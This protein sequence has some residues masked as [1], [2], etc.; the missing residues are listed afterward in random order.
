VAGIMAS[1]A[2]PVHLV[3]EKVLDHFNDEVKKEGKRWVPDSGASNHMSDMQ[4]IFVELDTNIHGTVRFGDGS[5]VEIMGIGTILFVCRNG[6]HMALTGVY[7]I[8][9]LTTNIM[10]L[11]Q[12]DEIGYEVLI[13][14]GV[15]EV[16]DEH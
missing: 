13:R 10:S 3:E 5:V 11:G 14:D 2:G 6:K 12:L 16:H 4:E 9:K 1:I 8:P 15:M 7:L